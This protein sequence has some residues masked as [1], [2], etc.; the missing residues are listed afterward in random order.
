MA[1]D[2][3]GSNP[4]SRPKPPFISAL[5]RSGKVD[6]V[7][8][9]PV[10]RGAADPKTKQELLLPED[11]AVPIWSNA[12]HLFAGT[13][14]WAYA[15]WKPDFYPKTV[16]AKKF[17]EY[18]GTRL[19]SVEVNYTFRALPTAAMLQN[20]LSAV[21]EGFRFSFKAPQRVTHIKR[22]RECEDAVAQ[23]LAVLEPVQQAGKL[24]SVLFQLPPNFKAD[25]PRLHEFLAIPSLKKRK[26]LPPLAFEFRHASWFCD[27]LY[28]L[29]REYNVAL[30]VAESEDLATPEVFTAETHACYRLR[31]PGGYDAAA[32]HAF[33]AKFRAL[34]AERDVYVYFKHED[35][36][37]GPLAAAAMLAEAIR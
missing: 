21:P 31:M 24:G 9:S 18:Y 1:P 32:S 30:C 17:L 14:G 36:P 27:D 35:A 15:T 12:S 25:L 10:L 3:E 5:I 13:S 6:G 33:A 29:L 22:L 34:A 23:F 16:S 7:P 37:T 20:W 2:V 19:N 26:A 4:S 8:S 28:A 11:Q